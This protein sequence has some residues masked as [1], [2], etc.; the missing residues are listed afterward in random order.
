M[1][2]N[3]PRLIPPGHEP[4][5]VTL[6]EAAAQLNVSESTLYKW[7]A[8]RKYPEAMYKLGAAVRI[9]VEKL[10]TLTRAKEKIP[11]RSVQVERGDT[12]VTTR[13]GSRMN[14]EPNTGTMAHEATVPRVLDLLGAARYLSVSPLTIKAMD[15]AWLLPRVRLPLPNQGELR[16]LLFDRADLDAAIEAWKERGRPTKRLLKNA[17]R[18]GTHGVQW[19]DKKGASEGQKRSGD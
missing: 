8:R 7:K 14:S 18:E 17:A 9:D 19:R 16:K 5:L 11:Q 3:L 4:T 6:K 13:A 1:I 10:R 15:A 2:L 12:T